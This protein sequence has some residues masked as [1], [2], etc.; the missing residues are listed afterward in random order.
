M[1]RKI[2]CGAALMCCALS[3]H[4]AEQGFDWTYTGF[5]SENYQEFLPD[6]QIKGRFIVDDVDQNGI[7]T[8]SEVRS[9][10]V[11]GTSWTN[12][13][14]NISCRLN[15]FSYTPGGTLSFNANYTRDDTE[16][17]S[18][19]SY[20]LI[21]A[22]KYYS[23]VYEW[24]GGPLD[25]NVFNFTSETR[26]AISPVPEPQTWLM[27]GAGLALLGAARRRAAKR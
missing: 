27:L 15:A 12:C 20:E 1:I 18:L 21:D 24:I 10:K 14:G 8:A 6:R 22:T 7:F 25:R 11:G 23:Q 19:R 17:F 2:L 3:G 26:F 5:W 13:S 4:A 16:Y 9:F